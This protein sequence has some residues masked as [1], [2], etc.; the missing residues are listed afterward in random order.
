MWRGRALVGHS[1]V[2]HLRGPVTPLPPSAP[3]DTPELS[4]T[5]VPSALPRA[6]LS[7]CDAE[8]PS[9]TRCPADASQSGDNR[10]LR[11]GASRTGSPWAGGDG[12]R[13]FLCH[14]QKVSWRRGMRVITLYLLQNA[15]C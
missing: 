5:A 3:R 12:A 8:H 13:A 9:S 15:S 7:R 6:A 4:P 11:R 1:L 10:R 2:R 14:L